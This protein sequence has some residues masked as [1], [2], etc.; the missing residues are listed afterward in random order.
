MA[1]S[2]PGR[3]Q[4]VKGVLAA[5]SSPL[6]GDIPNIIPFQF[7][8]SDL[9]R[10]VE[11][12]ATDT[13]GS[14]RSQSVEARRRVQGPPTE[15]ISL[16]LFLDATDKLDRPE[17]HPDIAALGLQ[18]PLAAL[19]LLLHPEGETTESAGRSITGPGRVQIS[20]AEKKVPLLLFIWGTKAL[21]V[22]LTG[23]SIEEQAFDDRLNPIRAEVSVDLEVLTPDQ[24]EDG[25]GQ[26]A[27]RATHAQRENWAQLNLVGSARDLATSLF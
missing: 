23:L 6:I 5:Y 13:E 1:Q 25:I 7:N 16:S 3:P 20:Y 2:F 14:G 24:L 8:P 26:D 4:L 21:P 27:Y 22:R 11:R 19:E 9:S 10:T 15:T 12:R 18:P 17:L